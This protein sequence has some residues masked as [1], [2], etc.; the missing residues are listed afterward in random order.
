[1]H[2]KAINNP[3]PVASDSPGSPSNSLVV[4]VVVATFNRR[5]SLRQLLESLAQQ[6]LSPTLFEVVI[7]SDGSTDGTAELVRGLSLSRKNLKLLELKNRGPGAARNAGARA[8]RGRYLAFTDDD[9]LA[10]EDWLEQLLLVFERTGAVGVQGRTTT[11]R[12]ARTPLTHEIEVLSSWL[13]AMPTCNAAYR[14][15]V[16]ERV[17]GFDESFPFAHN[18]DADLAWRVEDVG[19]TVFAPEVHVVHPPRRDR[20]SKHARWVRFLA[21]E[22]LLYYKNPGK[23]RKYISPSPWWTIYGKVFVIGQFHL[24][25]SSCKYL[26]KPFR[27]DYFIVAL[28]LLLARWF[29]LIRFFPEYCKA[30]KSCRPEVALAGSMAKSEIGVEDGREPGSS[31]TGAEK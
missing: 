8:A 15:D 7:A 18:E 21:S 3:T 24:A 9:C 23:Y 1:M 28:G 20:F 16:F 14:K 31:I 11:D 10:S 25:K 6:T 5:E 17:G 13:A 30:Q 4:S 26:F 27:P 12:A 2:Q 22:F 19:K 29:N